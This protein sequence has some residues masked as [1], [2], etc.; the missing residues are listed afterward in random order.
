M[1]N[2]TR[3][4]SDFLSKF[5]R[6]NLR[7]EE[8]CNVR[9][10]C[11]SNFYMIFMIEI[12]NYLKKNLVFSACVFSWIWSQCKL[13]FVEQWSDIANVVKTFPLTF[14]DVNLILGHD[15]ANFSLVTK[16]IIWNIKLMRG[17]LFQTK[18]TFFQAVILQPDQ[19]L[20]ISDRKKIIIIWKTWKS[21]SLNFT[22]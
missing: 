21:F 20:I 2:F 4:K 6:W 12:R 5:G 13:L 1:T 16:W 8:N 19:S 17:P 9:T 22:S 14:L 7:F 18:I 10:I 15:S 11:K 3:R